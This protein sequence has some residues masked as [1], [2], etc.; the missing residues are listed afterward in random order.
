MVPN[1]T[2]SYTNYGLNKRGKYKEV[3]DAWGIFNVRK[4]RAHRSG[5]STAQNYDNVFYP[6]LLGLN[7]SSKRVT[8][9]LIELRSLSLVFQECTNP[10]VQ[11]KESKYHGTYIR[12]WLRTYCAHMKEKRYFPKKNNQICDLN[13]SNNRDCSLR[14]HLFLKYHLI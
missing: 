8:L 3:K 14:A 11:S 4:S 2:I 1:K 6:V 13:R 9:A 7:V 5:G 12:W 10:R